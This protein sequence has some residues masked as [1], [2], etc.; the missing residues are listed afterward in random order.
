MKFDQ[1]KTLGVITLFIW[2][3]VIGGCLISLLGC[4][5][6]IV[7]TNGHVSIDTDEVETSSQTA[8]TNGV[9]RNVETNFDLNP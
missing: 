7:R 1:T 2:V 5:A 4:R 9:N 8:G 6:I 3:I